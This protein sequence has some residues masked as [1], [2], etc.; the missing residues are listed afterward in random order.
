[1]WI[2]VWPFKVMVILL[3]LMLSSNLMNHFQFICIINRG[4]IYHEPQ[5]RNLGNCSKAIYLQVMVIDSY[6]ILWIWSPSCIFLP[7]V[8][9]PYHARRA[10]KILCSYSRP[11]SY[12]IYSSGLIITCS[13]AEIV[14]ICFEKPVLCTRCPCIR[15]SFC[16]KMSLDDPWKENHNQL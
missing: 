16:Y 11:T 3:H 9:C 6:V 2:L 14:C 1:M 12:C 4:P 10:I 5:N 7:H 8:F 15:W 13:R